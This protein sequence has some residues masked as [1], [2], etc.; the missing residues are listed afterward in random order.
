MGEQVNYSNFEE[1]VRMLKE[2]KKT[3]ENDGGYLLPP[4]LP[5]QLPGFKAW[6]MRFWGELF[7]RDD[8]YNRGI[9]WKD[10]GEV[11]GL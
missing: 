9:G 1:F 6:L 10:T 7:H 2:H 3:E 8:I 5:Y 11:L 4:T